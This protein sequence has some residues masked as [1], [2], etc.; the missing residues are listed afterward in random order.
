MS[1]AKIA[2]G[3]VVLVL[4]DLLTFLGLWE[5]NNQYIVY[6]DKLAGGL[7]TVCRGLTRHVTK[8]PIIVGETWSAE[9][10]HASS[11]CVYRYGN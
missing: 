2:G 4:V 3:S 11:R 1:K 9:K 10:C 6:S 7:P 5:R 8:T